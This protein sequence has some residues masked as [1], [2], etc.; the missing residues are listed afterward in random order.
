MIYDRS[1]KS[2]CYNPETK[3]KSLCNYG[4]LLSRSNSKQKQEK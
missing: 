2:P 1:N 4:T 3:N